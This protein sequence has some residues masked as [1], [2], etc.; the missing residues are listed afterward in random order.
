MFWTCMGDPGASDGELFS[1]RTDGSD[2][3]TIVSAGTINT[4]KQISLDAAAQKVYFCDR[5]GCTVYRCDYDGSHL[6]TLVQKGATASVKADPANAINWC[7]GIAVSPAR[8][9]FYW[10]QKGP[11]K[12]E[13]GRIFCANLEMPEGCSAESRSDVKCILYGLPEPIDLELDEANSRLYW[14]DRGELPWGNSLNRVDLNNEGLP[15]REVAM[16]LPK[17]FVIARRFN[18]AIGLKIDAA[19]DKVYVADLGGSIYSCDLD[20]GNKTKIFSDDKHSF[21]GIALI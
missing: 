13:K 10:T 19:R 12:G 5:E 6:E 20:G 7:V 1:A 3:R 15:A 8:G 14:T 11:S 21:T 9:K 18:E 2:V 16:G 17:S 4:P